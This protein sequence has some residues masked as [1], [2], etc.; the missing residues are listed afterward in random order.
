MQVPL[1]ATVLLIGLAQLLAPAVSF[2]VDMQPHCLGLRHNP[3]TPSIIFVACTVGIVWVLYPAG[4]GGDLLKQRQL[5]FTFRVG[6]LVYMAAW[7]VVLIIG[8]KALRQCIIS[9]HSR[10]MRKIS[11]EFYVPMSTDGLGSSRPLGRKSFDGRDAV[12]RNTGS[13][14]VGDWLRRTV[15]AIV[16][17][18]TVLPSGHPHSKMVRGQLAA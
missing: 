9:A 1:L 3:I 4:F 2:S 11:A 17:L 13:T 6:L 14:D 12:L 8:M 18:S 10:R 15:S 5:P 7:G 16:D